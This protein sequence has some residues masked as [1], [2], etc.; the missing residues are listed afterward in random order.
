MTGPNDTDEHMD[1]GLRHTVPYQTVAFSVFTSIFI[2]GFFGNMLVIFV[3]FRSKKMRTLTNYYLVSLACADIL[4]L[5]GGTLTAIPELF[6][7]RE[8]WLYGSVM[9][10][11]FVFMQYLGINA[12]A[13]SMTAF[14]VERYVGICYPMKAQI[15]YT[16]QR[17]KYIIAV[18]WVISVL[19]NSCWLYLARTVDQDLGGGLVIQTCTFRIN[20]DQY[21]AIY[22]VDLI[23]FYVIPLLITCILYTLIGLA[24][25]R[26]SSM[27]QPIQ[28]NKRKSTEKEKTTPGKSIRREDRQS[29]VGD[30]EN[31][32]K[33]ASARFQVTKQK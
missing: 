17:A 8:Q 21:R 31:R 27:S 20:R 15:I 33:I 1:G 2:I 6:F 9:C 12:S 23:L 11:V 32:K 22:M 5:I 4:V 29:M 13:L 16:P 14:T 10:S 30:R 26:S 25:H 24:L 18:L 28:R 7:Y 19:Y 3:V